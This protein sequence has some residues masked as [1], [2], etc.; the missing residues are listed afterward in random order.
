MSIKKF[1]TSVVVAASLIAANLSPLATAANAGQGGWKK[2]DDKRGYSRNYDSRRY[3]GPR[4]RYAYKRNR[5]HGHSHRDHSGNDIA[6]GF[7][8]GLGILAVGSILASSHR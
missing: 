1:T 7:A 8:I 2:Y 3:D 4:H 6:K 5:D